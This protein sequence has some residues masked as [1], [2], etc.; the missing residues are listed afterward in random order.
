M[1]QLLDLAIPLG[2]P[3]VW[4]G[5]ENALAARVRLVLETRPG[6]L[7]WRP[8]FGCDL[9]GLVGFPATEELVARVRQ[10]ISSALGEWIPDATVVSVDVRAVPISS[11]LA[12]SA[13][14]S[15][16]AA[17]AAMLVLGV[18]AELE[19]VIELTGPDGPI[20]FTTTVNP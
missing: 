10:R 1:S 5:G 17:E 7:P 12:L 16:P 2:S 9:D 6:R 19:A 4:L 20:T 18:Q 14:R 15:V 11:G 13:E 8:T 3:L